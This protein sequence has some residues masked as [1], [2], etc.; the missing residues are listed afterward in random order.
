MALQSYIK[1]ETFY[2][3]KGVFEQTQKESSNFEA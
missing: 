1:P 3:S 2:S